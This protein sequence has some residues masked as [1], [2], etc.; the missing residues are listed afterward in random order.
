MCHNLGAELSR[1]EAALSTADVLKKRFEAHATQMSTERDRFAA[2][3]AETQSEVNVSHFTSFRLRCWAFGQSCGHPPSRVPIAT[4][5]E[6]GGWPRG[7]IVS[8]FSP[9][10]T[11]PVHNVGALA[12][13]T[14][15]G[16]TKR[17]FDSKGDQA[18]LRDCS[19]GTH[20]CWST[21]GLFGRDGR[22][23]QHDRFPPC[24]ITAALSKH[25][26]GRLAPS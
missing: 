23:Q 12:G 19:A 21:A 18:S 5:S 11:N 16:R 15:V 24:S 1:V 2:Q 9:S 3:L 26:N 25:L 4:I 13:A 14:S 10:L 22:P 8:V 20:N 6:V 17:R 7:R